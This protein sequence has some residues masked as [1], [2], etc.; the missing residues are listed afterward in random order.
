[1]IGTHVVLL[2]NEENAQ[3]IKSL[4][5]RHINSVFAS[6]REEAQAKIL[7]LI[8]QRARARNTDYVVGARLSEHR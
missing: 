8:P 7:E 5:M 3:T 1:M 2:M 4:K 6:D